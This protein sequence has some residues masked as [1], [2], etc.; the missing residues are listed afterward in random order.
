VLGLIICVRKFALLLAEGHWSLI[1]YII[2][3]KSIS[4][5]KELVTNSFVHKLTQVSDDAHDS[6]IM[7]M[8]CKVP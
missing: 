4:K 2:S 8:L 5:L 3:G 7:P 6:V 1:G